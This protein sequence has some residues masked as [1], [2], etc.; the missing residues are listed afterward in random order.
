MSDVAVSTFYQRPS[1]RDLAD[2]PMP[3]MEVVRARASL[4]ANQLGVWLALKTHLWLYGELPAPTC[5]SQ[6]RRLADIGGVA[7]RTFRAMMPALAPL[8]DQDSYGRWG[9]REW[10]AERD[11]RLDL[12]PARR[13]FVDDLLPADADAREPDPG[14]SRAGALGGQ[15][16]AETRRNKR[17]RLLQGGRDENLAPSSIAPQTADLLTRRDLDDLGS[18]EAERSKIEADGEAE[19]Q[20]GGEADG[21]AGGKQGVSSATNQPTDSSLLNQKDNGGLVGHALAPDGKQIEAAVE[22]GSPTSTASKTAVLS[23]ETIAMAVMK[24]T[25]HKVSRGEAF[26][27]LPLFRREVAPEVDLE[28]DLVPVLKRF[29]RRH[30][31]VDNW[32]CRPILDDAADRAR[33]RIR[34]GGGQRAASSDDRVLVAEGSPSWRAWLRFKKVASHMSF[35]PEGGGARG[36]RFPSEWPPGWDLERLAEAER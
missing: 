16:S 2:M 34:N 5:P 13:V 11:R 8:F 23:D 12:P 4:A 28:V 33:A 6:V 18:G 32:A 14:K 24:A 19:R 7:S 3:T 29:A 30:D 17:L 15:R 22:A 26:R 9:D 20:A 25:D 10:E 35:Q 36:W 31:R 27:F 21:Q 1:L